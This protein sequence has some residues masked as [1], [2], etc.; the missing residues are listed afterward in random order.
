MIDQSGGVHMTPARLVGRVRTWLATQDWWYW[1]LLFGVV[2]T[3]AV[4]TGA[5]LY[6][7]V[8]GEGAT[9]YL[10]ALAAAFVAI[11]GVV[12]AVMAVLI[13][14]MSPNYRAILEAVPGGVGRAMNP[15]FI[16]AF[17]AATGAIIALLSAL[18]WWSKV[19]ILGLAS[20]VAAWLLAGSAM[21]LKVTFDHGSDSGSV[22][23]DM[24]TIRAAREARLRE[25]H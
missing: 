5:C 13:G 8:R 9:T 23:K 2:I 14:L 6:P 24:A 7:A 17:G 3:A 12:M 15:Y 10:Y 25:L 16:V 11:L 20:G 21:L 1:D 4:V 19:V 18:V 22:D